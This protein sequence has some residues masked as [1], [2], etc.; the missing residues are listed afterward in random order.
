MPQATVKTRTAKINKKQKYR[1]GGPL[2]MKPKLDVPWDLLMTFIRLG[3]GGGG[4]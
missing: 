2:Q 4:F 1:G 3:A